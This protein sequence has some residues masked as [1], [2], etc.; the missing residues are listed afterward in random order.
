MY[1]TK[2]PDILRNQAILEATAAS[3]PLHQQR[4]SALL[5][6]LAVQLGRGS[7]PDVKIATESELPAANAVHLPVGAHGK[8]ARWVAALG[9][10]GHRLA[11][12]W[13]LP[14]TY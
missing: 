3:L 1:L 12:G 5:R 7:H 9:M 4:F 14:S 10:S 13:A 8:A 11:L 6:H 2:R